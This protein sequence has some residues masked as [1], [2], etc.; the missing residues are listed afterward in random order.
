MVLFSDGGMATTRSATARSRTWSSWHRR[1]DSV[2]RAGRITARTR[3]RSSPTTLDSGD[4]RPAAASTPPAT[5]AAQA[6]ADIDRVATGTIQFKQYASLNRATCSSRWGLRLSGLRPPCS[7]CHCPISA[8]QRGPMS[9]CPR[10]RLPSSCLRGGL[11]EAALAR[12]VADAH[13]RL[14]TLT[15]CRGRHRGGL[16]AAEPGRSAD[17]L[18]EE[19]ASTAP[20]SEYWRQRAEAAP[21][22]RRPAPLPGA[23]GGNQAGSTRPPTPV[24][25][26]ATSTAFRRDAPDDRSAAHRQRLDTV[27]RP[28]AR[29]YDSSAN[30]DAAYNYSAPSASAT[31]SPGPAPTRGRKTLD[32]ELGA[33]VDL[34]AGPIHGRPGGPPPE[35]PG[36]QFRIA[37]CHAKEREEAI[38]RAPSPQRRG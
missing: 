5:D 12:R 21:R 3:A 32:D 11:E 30:V 31:P 22:T 4:R 9:S 35:I 20:R 15:S 16:I 24:M 29:C 2:Y 23:R 34:P 26:V 14:A 36:D 13:G 28:T 33:S 27:I 10:L 37:P 19:V 7:N 6:I 17:A 18:G 8:R 1:E 25:F 38:G